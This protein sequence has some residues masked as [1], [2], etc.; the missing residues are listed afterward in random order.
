[1]KHEKSIFISIIAILFVLCASMAYSEER[2]NSLIPSS[3]SQG[4]SGLLITVSNEGSVYYANTKKILGI[5]TT[6]IYRHGTDAE[7][8][9]SKLLGKATSMIY[10]NNYLYCVLYDDYT[11]RG[12]LISLSL[13]SRMINTLCSEEYGCGDLLGIQDNILYFETE[14]NIQALNL[15]DYNL[16]TVAK[17]QYYLT[18]STNEG[19]TYYNGLNY[20]FRPWDSFSC[21]YIISLPEGF[22]GKHPLVWTYSE[23]CFALFDRVSSILY[24][25][26]GQSIQQTISNVVCYSIRDGLVNAVVKEQGECTLLKADL[27]HCDNDALSSY[28]IPSSDTCTV[29]TDTIAYFDEHGTFCLYAPP[30]RGLYQNHNDTYLHPIS[31][32]N[33]CFCVLRV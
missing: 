17:K 25:I 9:L 14:E 1:M 24:L 20:V 28:R 33:T 19:I 27:V 18:T 6:T 7:V 31:V 22:Q 8:V 15:D 21:D 10:H 3:Y 11:W 16:R 26:K 23:E 13:S 5:S 29:F 12:R 2:M 32:S 4:E 30:N